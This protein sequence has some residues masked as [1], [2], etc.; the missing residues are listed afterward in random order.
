[1]AAVAA[2]LGEDASSAGLIDIRATFPGEVRTDSE[3]VATLNGLLDDS[4]GAARYTVELHR[5]GQQLWSVRAAA[6]RRSAGPV[7]GT[8]TSLSSPACSYVATRP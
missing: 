6:W 3:V 8:W 1:V 5:N 2:F 7:V 4:V